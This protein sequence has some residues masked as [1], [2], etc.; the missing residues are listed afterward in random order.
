MTYEISDCRGIEPARL[1]A[2]MNAAFSDYVV[3]MVLTED[4][5]RT[6]QRQRGF[7]AGHSFIASRDGEIAAFWFSGIPGTRY[8]GR[9]Y[10]LSVGTHPDHRRKRLAQRLFDAVSERQRQAGAGGLQLEVVTTNSRAIAAYTEFGFRSGRS[11]RVI[12]MP[13]ASEP[14]AKP[15]EILFETGA[16]GDLPD[17]EAVFFDAEP[18]PQN[19]REAV[20]ALWPYVQIVTA[21]KEREL[22]GWA[23]A[24]ED[25][26]VAQIAVRRDC[27]RQ[28]IGRALIGS[29]C[30]RVAA[31]ELTFVNVDEDAAALNAF[32]G[33][34]GAEEILRQSELRLDF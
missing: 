6:F 19:A 17:D 20:V 9:A 12:R 18:T 1:C 31:D 23:A 16:P 25:G 21:R 24:Y 7:S 15:R 14:R 28:G 3:P 29:I 27:R 10:T 8:G 11:L 34:A 5:F 2:A 13:K 26:A 4:R 32:L 22:L 30:R 33:A